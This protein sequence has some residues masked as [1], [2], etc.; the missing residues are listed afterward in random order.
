MLRRLMFAALILLMAAQVA[1]ARRR[2][3]PAGDIKDDVYTDSKYGFTLKIHENWK[4]SVNKEDDKARL[5]LAQRKYDIPL[6]YQN[7]PHYTW[8]PTL[9]VF[10]DS[11]SMNVHVLIDSLLND[12]FDSELK[13]DIKKEFELLSQR[14]VIAKGRTRWEVGDESGVI[15]TAQ[16]PYVKEVATSASSLGGKRVSSSYGGMI[17]AVEHDGVTYLF[18]LMC[19]WPYF[20]SIAAEVNQILASFE[21]PGMAEE[22]EE[23]G[24][25]AESSEAG[26]K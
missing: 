16:S 17:A 13:D 19:E 6:D 20:E 23:S 1:E 11:S 15:W 2:T 14:E 10:A 18:M 21:Y 9:T 26:T 3:P 4:P 7:V 5:V 22:S 24:E 25:G 12:E 8:V